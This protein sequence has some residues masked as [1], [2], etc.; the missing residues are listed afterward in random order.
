[1][2][3]G[4]SRAAA[5]HRSPALRVDECELGAISCSPYIM[6][7]SKVQQAGT[8]HCAPGIASSE[9]RSSKGPNFSDQAIA[10]PA[11]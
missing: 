3:D 5:D 2:V 11:V 9:L 4:L 10:R 1:M 6:G 7:L 8:A